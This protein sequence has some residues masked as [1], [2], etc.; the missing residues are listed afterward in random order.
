M[1]IIGNGCFTAYKDYKSHSSNNAF[2]KNIPQ[3]I[4]TITIFRMDKKI[5]PSEKTYCFSEQDYEFQFIHSSETKTIL[6]IP[7]KIKESKTTPNNYACN[8]NY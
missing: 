4:H 2:L 7:L 6:N 3:N 1:S 5:P 8:R